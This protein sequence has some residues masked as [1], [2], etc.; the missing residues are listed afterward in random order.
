MSD[1]VT[2]AQKREWLRA[3][4]YAVGSRGQ[5]SQANEDAYQSQKPA[6]QPQG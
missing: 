4:G 2:T 5:L 1:P 3:N 6:G